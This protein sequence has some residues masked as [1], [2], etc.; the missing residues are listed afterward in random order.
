MIREDDMDFYRT[1]WDGTSG[2]YY[3]YREATAE[4]IRQLE[5]REAVEKADA[6]AQR[7]RRNAIAALKKRIE[8]EGTTPRNEDGSQ[9]T[10][11]GTRYLNTQNIYGSGDWF[12]VT[13][14]AIWYVMNHGMDGD[15]WAANNVRT[16]GAGGIGSFIPYDPAIHE[17]LKE[18]DG[19]SDGGSSQENHVLDSIANAEGAWRVN[20]VAPVL[21]G[22]DGQACYQVIRYDGVV[23]SS[24]V[25]EA[26]ALRACALLNDE[27]FL[28]TPL[29]GSTWFN[30]TLLKWP[31]I[32]M[33][34]PEN[35]LPSA[36]QIGTP[37]VVGIRD[38]GDMQLHG[39]IAGVRFSQRKVYYRVA[40]QVQ[41]TEWAAVIECPS[42]CVYPAEGASLDAIEGWIL[43][44]T[45]MDSLADPDQTVY[46]VQQVPTDLIST[47]PGAYQWRD[48]ANDDGTEDR[49]IDPYETWD[50]DT[51]PLILHRRN[52][53]TLWVVDGHHR[54]AKAERLD[55]P[56]VPAV[57]LDE[58]DGYTVAAMRALCAMLNLTNE[59]SKGDGAS[60]DPV[61]LASTAKHLMA[62]Q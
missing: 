26:D 33:G 3:Y 40:L 14:S 27:E 9:I 61:I 20:P 46:A 36:D 1:E 50:E 5:Q 53:S 28:D 47:D 11:G 34:P 60:Y 45:R 13:D 41:G 8:T 19:K 35:K 29:P 7:A 56:E 42:E 51:P 15:N 17:Q 2:A 12:E 31:E 4:E 23:L 24:F 54:L 62:M 30:G 6:D 37:V 21:G 39:V 52:D 55:V 58:D 10:I 43:D 16:G 25:S 59:A 38:Q 57:I 22:G 49:P 48:N 44:S 32:S 18:W